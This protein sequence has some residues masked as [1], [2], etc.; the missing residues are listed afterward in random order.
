VQA[1]QKQFLHPI[2]HGA[3][4]EEKNTLYTF[5]LKSRLTNNGIITATSEPNNGATFDI[6]I[7]GA[8]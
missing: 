5:L 2:L 7:P 8:Q 3:V 4:A 1:Q 6:Y